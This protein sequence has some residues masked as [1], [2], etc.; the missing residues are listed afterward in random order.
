MAAVSIK[1]STLYSDADL[2]YYWEF[3]GNSTDTKGGN[4]G[5]DTAI[6]YST[7]NG[8]F[9]QG[10]GFTIASSS[11][12]GIGQ[13]GYAGQFSFLAWFKTSTTST[14]QFICQNWKETGAPLFSGFTYYVDNSNHLSGLI[15]RNTGGLDAIAGTTNVC[16]GNWHFGAYTRDATNIHIYVDGTEDAT[17]VA[18][19][20]ASYVSTFPRI[21]ARCNA[22]ANDLFMNGAIDDLA[23]FNRCLSSTEINNHWLGNDSTLSSAAAGYRGLLGVGV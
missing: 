1:N 15:A 6:T 8:K 5:T 18:A 10:A 9:T 20:A 4:N 11:A 22:G 19:A 7:A 3:E 14:Y 12:I 23:I 13:L 2:N 16:D 17:P 21:G